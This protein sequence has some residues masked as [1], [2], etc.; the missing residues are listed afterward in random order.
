MNKVL[1]IGCPGSGKSFFS[2]QLHQ[3]TALPLYHLDRMYWNHDKTIVNRSKFLSRLDTVLKADCWIL[4]GN[5]ESTLELRLQACDCVFFLD[6]S[7]DVCIEGV[8]SR[9]GIPRDDLPWLERELDDDFIQLIHNFKY[10]QRPHIV[11]L[12]NRCSKE[13]HIFKSR[14]VAIKYLDA[15]TLKEE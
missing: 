5:Y 7:L 1:V 12:L 14:E 13:V 15:L 8:T 11:Q 10:K 4:D 2:K 6:Y 3:C 9:I